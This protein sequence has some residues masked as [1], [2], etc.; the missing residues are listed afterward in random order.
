LIVRAKETWMKNLTTLSIVL[1]L[2]A[3][4]YAGDPKA[5][6]GGAP[7]AP[8]ADK[9]APPPADAKMPDMKP[10]PEIAEMAKAMAGTWKCS[11][12]VDMGGT[13]VDIKGT[14]THKADLD[15]Y[16]IRS[17]INGTAGK[18]TMKSE[19]LTTYDA[20]SKKWYRSSFNSHGGHGTS[21]GT[22][23]DKKVSWEGDA[24]FMS[25]PVK[26]RGTEDMSDPKA[27]AHIVGEFSKDNGKTWQKDHDVT[28]KK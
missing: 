25:G 20:G 17:T 12:Q 19:F 16:W 1:A 27:G 15:G 26:I 14:V 6:G 7:P 23:A 2:C 21:W 3:S 10:A 18:M 24:Q 22:A 4:A 5:G 11:G 8:P 13:M 9:K 28:C